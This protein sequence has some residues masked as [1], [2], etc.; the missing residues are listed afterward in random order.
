MEDR[1]RMVTRIKEMLEFGATKKE[2]CSAYR[3]TVDTFTRWV[4][5]LE[6]ENKNAHS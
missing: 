2:A 1:K 6:M 4:K 3:I 5:W